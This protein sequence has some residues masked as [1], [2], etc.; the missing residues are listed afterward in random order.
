VQRAYAGDLDRAV[1]QHGADRNATV[2]VSVN[3]A[4]WAISRP[5]GI[6]VVS[7]DNANGAPQAGLIR[8]SPWGTTTE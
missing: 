5:L 3:T 6:M 1:C 2:S 8:V 4:E 7:Q